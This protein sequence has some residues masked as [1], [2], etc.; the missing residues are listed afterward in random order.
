MDG[1]KSVH[2][3]VCHL[4]G[5][6]RELISYILITDIGLLTEK[7]LLGFRFIIVVFFVFNVF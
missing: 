2:P 5:R 7:K 4:L 1:R 3:S 6:I